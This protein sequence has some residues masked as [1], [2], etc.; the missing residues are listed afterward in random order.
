[1]KRYVHAMKWSSNMQYSTWRYISQDDTACRFLLNLFL[2]PWT[3]RRCVPPKRR[4]KLNGLH[5]V[6]S[7]KMISP[8][9]FCWTYFFHMDQRETC[10][11]WDVLCSDVSAQNIFYLKTV[12]FWGC[13]FYFDKYGNSF[14]LGGRGLIAL[15]SKRFFSSPQHPY[16][17][18]SSPSLV[19]NGYWGLFPCG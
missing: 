17:L 2:P 6:I 14:G 8:A 7:H 1:M 19:S 15:R 13:G 3:W 16:W 5:G 10:L 11:C 4:L 18:W 12:W 9:G